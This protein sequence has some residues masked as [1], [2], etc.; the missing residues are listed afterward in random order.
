MRELRHGIVPDAWRPPYGNEG[1]AASRTSQRPR[2]GAQASKDCL[3]QYHGIQ[4][5]H[6]QTSTPIRV[7]HESI[8]AAR[9]ARPEDVM[10]L[11]QDSDPAAQSSRECPPGER[12][13]GRIQKGYHGS[14]TLRS[15]PLRQ[16]QE[17]Q[18]VLSTHPPADRKGFSSG[19]RG[20]A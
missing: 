3:Q 17:I 11:W 5:V 12:G 16:R 1:L 13:E 20:T 10:L 15:V 7:W 14:R 6:C 19:C 9:A 2:N 4:K 18:V 8:D